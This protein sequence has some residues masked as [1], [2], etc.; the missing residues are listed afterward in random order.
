MYEDNI[1]ANAVRSYHKSVFTGLRDMAVII[2]IP[3]L[4]LMVLSIGSVYKE[5]EIHVLSA[6]LRVLGREGDLQW[7]PPIPPK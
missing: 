2:I 1:V 7:P 4:C 5:R 6:I 3:L